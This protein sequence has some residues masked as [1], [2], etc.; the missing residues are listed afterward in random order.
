MQLIPVSPII[1]M[2][3]YPLVGK[4]LWLAFSIRPSLALKV[5]YQDALTMGQGY[6]NR[7]ILGL[8]LL[9][10]VGIIPFLVEV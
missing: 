8:N 2:K 9:T 10:P 5:P 6:S 4:A 1:T 3:A 7:D